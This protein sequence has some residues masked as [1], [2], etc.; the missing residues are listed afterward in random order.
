MH[1]A[2]RSIGEA[3]AHF[4]LL[5]STLRYDEKETAASSHAGRG[6]SLFISRKPRPAST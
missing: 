1:P 4:G 5:K 2:D 3:S 6:S